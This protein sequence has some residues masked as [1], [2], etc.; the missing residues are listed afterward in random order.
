MDMK[1]KKNPWKDLLT[2]ISYYGNTLL[3]G[4]EMIPNLFP[5]GNLAEQYFYIDV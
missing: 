4:K 5:I 3:S 2:D 1:Q